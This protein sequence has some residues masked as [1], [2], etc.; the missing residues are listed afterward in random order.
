M[1]RGPVGLTALRDATTEARAQHR[2]RVVAVCEWA[3]A[4]GRPLLPSHI[5]L[6]VAAKADRRQ[7]DGE[8]LDHWTRPGVYGH[9][10]SAMFNWCTFHDTRVP[11][12]LPEALWTYLHY[13]H[14]HAMLTVDSDPLKALLDPLRCYGGLGPDGTTATWRQVKCRCRIEYRPPR[15]PVA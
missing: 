4:Q 14:E 2:E 8:A 13:L 7:D 9:L 3:L 1:R 5:A 6:I 10:Y 15:Q 11:V 12:D